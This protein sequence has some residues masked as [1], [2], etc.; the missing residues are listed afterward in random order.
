MICAFWKWT[1]IHHNPISVL[2][3]GKSKTIE[4]MSCWAEKILTK[5][6]D[7]PLKP[8]V[9]IVAATGKAAANVGKQ[10]HIIVE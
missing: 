2:G 1:T 6:G 7:H 9:L 4:A 10:I 5:V 3:A 8:R